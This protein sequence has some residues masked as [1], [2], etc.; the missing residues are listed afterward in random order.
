LD[1]K[2]KSPLLLAI[3]ALLIS[4]QIFA[5]SWSLT[6][7]S[8]GRAFL[9]G[10]LTVAG[11]LNY[12]GRSDGGTSDVLKLSSQNA[13]SGAV[14]LAVDQ[15]LLDY[16]ALNLRGDTITLQCKIPDPNSPSASQRSLPCFRMDADG[17][18]NIYNKLKPYG[19]I[20]LSAG[21]SYVLMHPTLG[22]YVNDSTDQYN[23]FRIWPDGTLQ[24]WAYGVASN[25]RAGDRYL[26]V[27]DQGIIRTGPKIQ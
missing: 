2:N 17:N 7:G 21:Q 9:P 25:H 6:F 16:R 27:D 10:T 22:L 12:F 24:A 23:R 13:G 20:D 26:M 14:V 15:S 18:A 3:F 4:S 8:D 19:P 11:T 1:N 5:Q